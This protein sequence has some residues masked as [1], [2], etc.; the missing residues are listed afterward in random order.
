MVG[1]C[2]WVW[3]PIVGCAARWAVSQRSAPPACSGSPLVLMPQPQPSAVS[4]VATESSAKELTCY[5]LLLRRYPGSAG[6]QLETHIRS[7]CS[8]SLSAPKQAE[9]LSGQAERLCAESIRELGP[10]L[11]N[12]KTLDAVI[13]A[14]QGNKRQWVSPPGDEFAD[15][16]TE[17][18]TALWS[19]WTDKGK[20]VAV[21][22]EVPRLGN[23]NVPTCVAANPNDPQSCSVARVQGGYP[24]G[25]T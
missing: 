12:D 5:R 10:K 15:Q 8:P 6:C 2:V 4:R 25:T 7:G 22:Q 9:L 3:R 1:A 21:L 23:K 13:V 18:F 11:A 19:S 16:K 17:G 14:A 20:I 24:F